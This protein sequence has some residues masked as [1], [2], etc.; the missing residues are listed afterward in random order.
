MIKQFN[1]AIVIGRTNCGKSSFLNAMCNNSVLNTSHKSQTTKRNLK[2]WVFRK[3]KNYLFWDTPG[4]TKQN[5]YF[6]Q[7]LVKTTFQKVQSLPKS[8]LIV[9]FSSQKPVNETAEKFFEQFKIFKQPKILIL[10]KVDLLSNEKLQE[11]YQKIQNLYLDFNQIL[12]FSI[13]NELSAHRNNALRTISSLSNLIPFGKKET[14]NDLEEVKQTTINFIK[15]YIDSYTYDEISHV[16]IPMI[17]TIEYI[18]SKNLMRI[19]C[20]IFCE[21]INQKKILI[22]AKGEFI[23]NLSIDVRKRIAHLF[24]CRFYLK[25]TVHVWRGWRNDE[26][27]FLE[28][29]NEI[30]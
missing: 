28:N 23:K 16:S 5:N 4:I 20:K 22:G 13:K 11:K 27:F 21:K 9:M 10:S 25:C 7:Y 2:I 17:E 14:E 24:Q 8:T 19:E 18:K 29:L 12:F 3:N 26:R 30:R 15:N 6:E 1:E